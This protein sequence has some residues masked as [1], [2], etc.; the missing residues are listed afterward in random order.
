[1]FELKELRV[2]VTAELGL[3]LYFTRDIE[4]MMT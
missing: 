4:V 1:M 3:K 2:A